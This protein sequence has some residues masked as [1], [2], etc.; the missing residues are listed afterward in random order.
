MRKEGVD[1]VHV[2]ADLNVA[3]ELVLV[4]FG[5]VPCSPIW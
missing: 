5:C 4:V 2:W 1:T 3:R